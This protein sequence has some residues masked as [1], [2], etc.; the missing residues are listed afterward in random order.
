[1]SSIFLNV[2][3]KYGDDI[4]NI[5][6]QVKNIQD[7]NMSF[8]QDVRASESLDGFDDQ[9][10]ANDSY[11]LKTVEDVYLLENT[12][13]DDVKNSNMDKNLRI[14]KN[15]QNAISDAIETHN[16]YVDQYNTINDSKNTKIERSKD[17]NPRPRRLMMYFWVFVLILFILTSIFTII[18][19]RKFLNSYAKYLFLFFV[20]YST[21]MYYQYMRIKNK[22]QP[23]KKIRVV[24]VKKTKKIN[25]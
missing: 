21:Y 25:T 13:V 18:E 10:L 5:K 3:T 4:K 16:H 9:I 12:M 7:K 11:I 1:M 14:I 8:I 19:D 6:S 23:K 22:H 2:D 15:K 20:A 17:V 24:V